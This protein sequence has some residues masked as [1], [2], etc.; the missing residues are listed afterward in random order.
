MTTSQEDAQELV[1]HGQRSEIDQSEV[2]KLLD[3]IIN[4]INQIEIL[5]MAITI[6][7]E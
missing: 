2:L 5:L 4:Q 7:R 6:V 3:A 1:V